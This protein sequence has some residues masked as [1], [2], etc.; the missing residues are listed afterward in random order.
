MASSLANPLAEGVHTF[1][2]DGCV[3]SYRVFGT[4]PVCV[5]HSGGPG[6]NWGYLRAPE[7]ERFL[8]MVYLEPAGT[9]G[10]DRLPSHPNGY[11]RVLYS[12][13]LAA[14]IDHLGVPRVHVLGH[15][16]GGFVAQHHA[17]HHPDQL[18][19]V[20][21]YDSAPVNGSELRDEAMRVVDG[22]AARHVGKPG[23]VAAVEAFKHG[24][25][26]DDESHLQLL[27]AIIPIYF[28]DYWSDERYARMRAAL[29]AT[30]VSG[31]DEYGE[32]G[33]FDDRIA[34]RALKVPTLVVVGRYD[35]ICGMRWGRELHQVIPGAKLLV[36]ERSGHFGHVEEP[37]RFAD[38][39]AAFVAATLP[40]SAVGG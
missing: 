24:D 20:V 19:G 25:F 34:L 7:L 13:H 22:L 31:L 8:T 3:L 23:L 33:I 32:P 2:V 21:L 15:S 1:A 9:G 10:S 11:V 36:L 40:A 12:R 5:A 29:D 18:A 6:V 28:A 16:Y 38:E 27:R 26:D 35:P 37:I 39:V 17:L 30:Y 14:L 4:G